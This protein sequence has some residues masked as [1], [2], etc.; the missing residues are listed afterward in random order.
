MDPHHTAPT[1]D[2]SAL[3]WVLEELR[4]T[5]EAANKSLRRYL[6]EVGAAEGS[7]LDD[8][9]PAIL[10]TAR[11]QIHQGVGALE[12]VNLP[13]G[14][15]LLRSA[16]Q[17]V[18]RFVAKPQRLDAAGVDAV[19][20]A[21]LALLDYL[22]QKLAGKPVQAVGLFAQWRVLLEL[23]GAE[24][25]HPAD[26]WTHDWR[27]REVPDASGGLAHRADAAMLASV[28]RALLGLMRQNTPAAAAALAR[29]GASLALAA[30]TTEEATVWRLA[31][32]FFQAWS[33]GLLAPDMFAKRTAS[34]VM[35]QLR[36][37]VRGE[38]GFSE[39]LAQ[40]LL[41]FCAR[42]WPAA[43]Q[44]APMLS[45]VQTAYHLPRLVPVDYAVPVYGLSDP[46]Q[47]QQ[48]RKRVKS[49]KEAWGLVSSPEAFRDPQRGVPLLDV[50]TLLGE[51]ISRL[52]D[53]GG[54]LARALV[55]A[56]TSV[57]R[58]SRPPGP[59]LGMEV[60]TSLLYLEAALDEVDVDRTGHADHAGRLA[61]RIERVT[62][63]QR[64]QPLE[65]WM[66]A[67][68]RRVSERL[69]LGSVVQELRATLGE[70]E[71]QIDQFFRS[72]QESGLLAGVPGLLGSMRGV[73][74]VLGIDAAIQTL[75]CMREDVEYLLHSE[76]QPQDPRTLS[77]FQRLAANLGALGFL[78][79]MLHVQPVVAK[80]LFHFDPLLGVLSPVMGRSAVT[81]DVIHRAE[82]IAEALQHAGMSREDVVAE[83]QALQDD[84]QVTALPALSAHVSAARHALDRDA[85]PAEV[86][87]ELQDF[88]A[89]AT[90]P[91]GLDPL[92]P[93]L[94]SRPPAP[95]PLD[96]PQFQ[97]TGLEDDDEMRGVF[98]DEAREVIEEGQAALDA[99]AL[100]PGNLPLLTHLRRAFH[101]LKGSARMVGFNA[102]GEAAWS[103]EQ[104]YNHWLA[105]Q[106][107]ASPELRTF[108]GDALRYFEAWTGAIAARDAE[109]FLPEPVMAGAEALRHA[110]ELMRVCLPGF[111][112]PPAPSPTGSRVGGSSDDAQEHVDLEVLFGEPARPLM[113]PLQATRPMELGD[114]MWRAP[115]PAQPQP[116]AEPSMLIDLPLDFSAPAVDVSFDDFELPDGPVERIEV[117]SSGL[118]DERHSWRAPLETT[119]SSAHATLGGPLPEADLVPPAEP[120]QDIEPL[121]LEVGE[122]SAPAAAPVSAP[123]L[124]NV[125]D[126]DGVRAQIATEVLR[127]AQPDRQ[128]DD[129]QIKVIGPLRL[130]IP[131]FNIY[132]NEA[133]EVS[134]RLGTE[135]TLWAMELPRPLG[136][137]AS[138][139]AHTLAGNSATVGFTE[140]AQL[141]RALEHALNQ[142]LALQ[143]TESIDPAEAELFVMVGDDIR[144]L[145]HQFAAGFLQ[146]AS[147]LI[148][149]RLQAWS[150]SVQPRLSGAA[151][152]SAPASTAVPVSAPVSAPAPAPVSAPAPLA[153]PP[154]AAVID[155]EF[156][157]DIDQIDQVDADLFPIFSEEAQELLP[158]L[159]AQVSAWLQAPTH[160]GA[161]TACMRTLH[162][163]KGS[164]R[165]AGA[166]RLGELA[167]RFESAIESLLVG[168]GP[169]SAAGLALLAQRVDALV[170]AFEALRERQSTPASTMVA[171]PWA[172]TTLAPPRPLSEELHQPVPSLAGAAARAA[173]AA[174]VPLPADAVGTIDWSRFL[175]PADSSPAAPAERVVLNP[176]PVRVRAAL[177][178]RLV[179]L[180]GEV[181]ITRSRLDAEVGHIR[182]SLGDLTDNLER[183]SRQLHDVTLQADTQLESRREA[184]RAAAQEF[185]SLELDRYTRLQELTRMMAESVNDVATVRSA[186]QRTLQTAEDE[187][188]VQARLTRELQGDLLRTRMVE[189]ESLSE[190][191][192]RVVRLA[193]KEVGKQ[194]RFDI[195]GGGVEVDRGVL[196]RMTAAFEHL[197]RNGVTH[198]IESPEQRVAAGKDP[199]GSITMSLV[200]EG[201]EVCVE[202]RDDGAGLDLG[203]IHARA[204]AMGLVQAD[205]AVSDTVLT[206]LIFAPGLSTATVL[207]EVAGRGVGMDVVKSDVQ[208]LGGRIEIRSEAS[209][210]TCFK[211]VLPLTTVVTQV[212]ILRAGTRSIAV[213]SNL[214]ELVQRTPVERV[215][216]AYH[217][218]Q[219]TYAGQTLPFYWLGALL[220][221]P[222]RSLEMSGRTLPVVIVRSAQQ[223]VALHV[224][225]V[226]GNHEVVVKNLG[227]QLARVPGLAG[228]TLLASGV[229]ALIY[230]P[231]ALAAV[232]GVQAQRLMQVTALTGP[233]DAPPVELVKPAPLV[234]VVDDSLTVR[235]ITKRLLER[236]G[237]RV[238]LAKDGLEALD[239]LAGER[240]V[241]VLSDIE[242]PR[243]DG[244][245]LLRNIRSDTR[246]AGL[247]V[248]MITSR[249]ASKH[250]DLALELG[251]RHY[252]G[253]PYSEDELLRLIASHASP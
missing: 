51:S 124:A 80:S 87:Q 136:E 53:D 217:E 15:L 48:T 67:L 56:A 94:T 226:L 63:G 37:R 183:L 162:T 106:T 33:L 91:L 93:P 123:G 135:L 249:I 250:R 128:G 17:L 72:P 188:A 29:D 8:V 152:V 202:L 88:V 235:R 246:L 174:P 35:A 216:Q 102:F 118:D 221:S 197:L 27:L 213:P 34:R 186:L 175:A 181:S 26:L 76:H 111:A 100:T 172:Q 229:V 52:Y 220:D 38:E 103:C 59:E 210:G 75:H 170:A 44:S 3:A 223:R 5:L 112:M 145:L 31:A 25:I 237:Y 206:D 139:L 184:A 74:S 79:D 201:N 204:V 86:R 182:S 153:A 173:T 77:A 224:D 208:S 190:R 96:L 82:A 164:A 149:E 171:A 239:L 46:A 10:R 47:I 4:K 150:Q 169:V 104:L 119:T 232:Y 42:A 198:G 97:P 151:V 129:D 125:I 154:V 195:V 68:Y 43:G 166:M 196:D 141:A 98:L 108:T 81:A 66:E 117:G 114:A 200:Q 69:T 122:P 32:A 90:A 148:G 21:A 131:L 2:L 95:R 228:M 1:D 203:R 137:E 120:P 19:E 99:L 244:F 61:E 39:R 14:A 187:L 101:T 159:E 89:T 138:A 58:S 85:D 194:V 116:P 241:V 179:N 54:Q 50:F 83:L 115:M 64:S 22:G 189:F 243:M 176:Q 251:A 225:D 180:A 126:L 142:V 9:E 230:N 155:H 146:T 157:A 7:D 55:A 70:I 16:E 28:E 219:Y 160:A 147:P 140:L 191:L 158:R 84:A 156:D 40:D 163:F 36:S 45:A 110:G 11:Q 73:L 78:I 6:R 207:T 12:L 234:L 13:E 143:A 65:P 252:L 109:A 236:E 30:Q 192:Y 41:F 168:G 185:D 167:H 49:A 132:L 238:A 199:V 227:A 105:E 218:G 92:G 121:D 233:D 215:A 248:V 209:R 222:G 231:V 62:A 242:M 127:A 193:A 247:P 214:I 71:Q 57:V 178:D 130:Q 205:T 253:K 107:P 144:R 23:N 24:R 165:L 20:K 240:P 212:V 245:D 60:A 113:E 18:Q 177:L 134:R 133:D 161:S 211:L